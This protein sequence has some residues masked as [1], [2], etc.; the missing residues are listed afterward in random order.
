MS[1]NPLS[2]SYRSILWGHIDQH[3]RPAHIFYQHLAWPERVAAGTAQT[4]EGFVP[5]VP[6]KMSACARGV[7][8]ARCGIWAVT[9]VGCAI[10]AVTTGMVDQ[11]CDHL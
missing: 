5:L 11:A 7:Q 6:S 1:R 2:R 8:P 4:L 9:P 10:K 3:W